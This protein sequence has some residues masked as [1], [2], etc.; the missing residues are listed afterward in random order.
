M[1]RYILFLLLAVPLSGCEDT[2]LLMLSDAAKDGVTA[3]SLSD[4]DVTALARQ[5]AAV[6]DRQRQLAPADSSYAQRLGRL[7]RG[8]V[9]RDGHGFN[10]KVYLSREVNAFALADGSIRVNSGLMELMS[11]PELLFV[12]GHEMGHVVN[13]HSRKQL[14]LAYAAS[15]LRKG[16][17]SQENEI[18]LMAR[19]L[20]GDLAQRLSHAQFSQHEER[21][22]DHYGVAFLEA[23]GHDRSAAI[24][25]LEKLA[26]LAREHSLLS[27]HPDPATRAR[28]LVQDREENGDEQVSILVRLLTTAKLVLLWT[29]RQAW[30]L[31][32]W[33]LQRLLSWW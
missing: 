3:I 1:I 6:S 23:E 20:L 30:N 26:L 11:D 10:F 29:V 28:Q 17:A 7:T 21:Q 24:S 32:Q 14:V 27:T 18:G 25:A 12:I 13:S 9:K 8:K 19:S 22:A 2:N 4:H 33:L 15:A 31:G 5:A 16:V